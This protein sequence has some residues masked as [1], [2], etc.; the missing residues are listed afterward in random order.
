MPEAF[1]PVTTEQDYLFRHTQQKKMVPKTE[2]SFPD[3]AV[4]A[5]FALTI[6]QELEIKEELRLRNLGRPLIRYSFAR[7]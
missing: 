5:N 1:D 7:Y 6:E 3:N 2:S 4:E